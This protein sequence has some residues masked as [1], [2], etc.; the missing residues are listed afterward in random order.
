MALS[1]SNNFDTLICQLKG[2]Y[3]PSG[4]MILVLQS[5]LCIDRICDVDQ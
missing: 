3:C 1:F 5:A 2:G 4:R